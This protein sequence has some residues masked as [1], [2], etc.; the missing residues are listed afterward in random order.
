MSNAPGMSA[1]A[2]AAMV[3]TTSALVLVLEI[4]AGRLM[5]PYVGVSLETFTGIIGTVLAG[6]AVGAAAG[7]ALADRR[8]PLTLIGRALVLGGGLTWLAI[9]I[10]T[11]LGPGMTGTPAD[12]VA[13]TSA[14]F[15]LP[16]AVLSGI[17][18]MVAKLRLSTLEE[19]GAVVGGLS[20]WGTFGALVGTF[21][22]GFVLIA[23][24]PVRTIIIAIGAVLVV[25]GIVVTGRS[26]G[27][28]PDVVESGLVVLVGILTLGI[29]SP[30]DHE[31]E[32]YCVRIVADADRPS[33]RSLVLDQVRH[34]HSDLDDPA[35]LEIRYVR[36]L[37]AA[38]ELVGPG[39]I[40]VL[41]IGGGGFTLPRYFDHVRP[42][43]DQVV[44]ELD[45]ELVDIARAELGFERGSNIEVR[46]GDARLHLDRLPTG[47]FDLIIGDAF[48]GD[49]VPW[50][51]TTREVMTEIRRM[52]RP[53]GLYAMN[54]IDGGSSGYSRAQLATL[55]DV[56]D[57]VTLVEPADGIGSTPVN[58][59][60][61]AG[62]RPIPALPI[63]PGDGRVVSTADTRDFVGDAPVLTDDFAPADQLRG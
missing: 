11:T 45:D 39:P 41:H 60:L 34:A 54:V 48:A 21:G 50:H 53:D 13:L 61:I 29:G 1:R 2:A 20:A 42:G 51:L 8:D 25:A 56:F 24:L 6:I 23:L 17:A 43:S 26:R 44:L 35:H 49:S 63:A 59:I 52:L 12:I 30:C 46:T 10:V 32:Y 28:R 27:G 15:L 47:A 19:T 4:V 40:E 16:A 55:Y 18:P 37:A 3:F 62:D 38:A 57:E 5:A 58:Q 36:L 7:G 31:T 14:G 22:T 9:P 33:G